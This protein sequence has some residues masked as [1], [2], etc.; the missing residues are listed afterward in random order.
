MRVLWYFYD[1]IENVGKVDKKLH[2]IVR[3][4]VEKFNKAI[5]KDADNYPDA[6]QEMLENIADFDRNDYY[7]HAPE[8]GDR[9]WRIR[10]KRL[11]IIVWDEGNGWYEPLGVEIDVQ[12]ISFT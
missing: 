3:S 2:A 7:E 6:M 5:D 12:E 4:E 8:Y 9:A 11:S 10:G 1:F